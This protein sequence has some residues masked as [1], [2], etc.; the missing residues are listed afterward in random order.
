MIMNKSLEPYLRIVR[1]GTRS[2][3][4][5]SNDIFEGRC[6][7][8]ATRPRKK[9]LSV[10]YSDGKRFDFI[11]GRFYTPEAF[12]TLFLISYAMSSDQW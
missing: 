8:V 1:E 12:V 3:R 9:T 6:K 11:Q 4:D 10:E 7:V 5:V 2:N